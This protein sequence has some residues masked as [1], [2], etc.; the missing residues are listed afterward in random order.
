MNHNTSHFSPINLASPATFTDSLPDSTDVVVVGG[1]IIG[2]ATALHLAER[3]QNVVVLEKG[4]VA[5]EQSSRNWG[6]IRQTGRDEGELPIMMESLAYWRGLASETGENSLAFSEQGVLYLAS[7]EEK[8][9]KF[10]AF[11]RLAKSHGLVSTV[12]TSEEVAKK[13]PA[14]SERWVGGLYTASDGRAEPWIAVP[15]LARAAQR[16]GVQ[17]IE[18]CAV[19][20]IESTAG[21]ITGVVSEKGKISCSRVL[22]AGGAWTSLL[23]RRSGVSLP[24]LSVKSTVMRVENL[25]DSCDT[26]AADE[27]IA[28]CRRSDG[29]H[30]V[31]LSDHHDFYIGPDAFRHFARY[32]QA[33]KTSKHE[34]RYQLKSPP[35][36]PD[37]WGTSRRWK[38]EDVSPFEANRILNPAPD[39]ALA[40]EM[41]KRLQRR[42]P[43]SPDITITH[44]W[45]GMIDTMPDFVPVL[46]ESTMPGLFIATGFSGHGFGIGPG[47]GRVMA[48]LMCGKTVGHDL[49]RF[50][51]GRFT[52]GS[53]LILGPH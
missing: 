23:A 35:G 43:A 4:R 9:H 12:L 15:A 45:A 33:M 5:G 53:D 22:L 16:A 44:L 34:T 46:D 26:N 30:S 28:F 47:A 24:Q 1:G 20:E 6:W 51:F 39:P 31:A 50:R 11:S 49:S 2:V 10:D 14:G 8:L 25:P 3:G 18:E 38:P 19:S 48:D 36:Y 17:V 29:G 42:F 27:R 37:A 21:R 32:R 13:L 7:S 41:L 40:T 52:D